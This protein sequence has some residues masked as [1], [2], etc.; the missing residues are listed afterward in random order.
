MRSFL[1]RLDN[2]LFDSITLCLHGL[3]PPGY[4]ESVHSNLLRGFEFLFSLYLLGYVILKGFWC[5]FYK[6]LLSL[7]LPLLLLLVV[8]LPLVNDLI[9]CSK[10]PVTTLTLKVALHLTPLDVGFPPIQEIG[11]PDFV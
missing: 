6:E 10:I 11:L 9:K 7:L 4:I 1:L 8:I 3:F 2:L 5:L